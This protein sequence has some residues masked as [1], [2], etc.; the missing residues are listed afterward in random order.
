MF[1]WTPFPT[2]SEIRTKPTWTIMGWRKIGYKLSFRW[3]F[4]FLTCSWE[5]SAVLSTFRWGRINKN[6]GFFR[7]AAPGFGRWSFEFLLFTDHIPVPFQKKKHFLNNFVVIHSDEMCDWQRTRN[8][9]TFGEIKTTK[10]SLEEKR[11]WGDP[12]GAFQGLQGAPKKDGKRFFFFFIK[13][14]K[15][16]QDFIRFCKIFM[17]FC[18]IW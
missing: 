11:V 16:L 8:P 3:F 14:Y 13:F 2:L 15:I 5:K 4:F 9:N 12:T 1:S 10:F 17:R 6:L 7:N 18:K